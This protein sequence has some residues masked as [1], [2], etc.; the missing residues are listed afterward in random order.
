MIF[1]SSFLMSILFVSC[2]AGK[3]QEQPKAP[4]PAAVSAVTVEKQKTVYFDQYPATV[5]PLN[6]DDIRAQV[7]GYITG[8]FF[9]DGQHVKKGEKLYDIDRQQY[10]ANLDQAN[11]NLN[12]A[13]ANLSKAQQD[14]DRYADLLNQDAIARQVYDH[15]VADLESAKMQVRAS[16]SNVRNVQST[17]NYAYINAPFSGTIGISQV[18]VGSLVTANQTLLNTLSSDDPMAVDL[19]VD[20]KQIPRFTQLQKSPNSIKDSVFTLDLP[21][22]IDFNAVGHVSLI[23]RAVDP[24]TGTIRTRL[25]FPNPQNILRAGMNINVRVKNNA[26]DTAM[27]LIPYKSVTEQMG[28]Y[29]V[30]IINDSSQ[31]IQH[32][33]ALGPRINDQVVVQQGVNEGDKVITEGF[34]KIKDSSRVMITTPKSKQ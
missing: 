16:E 6:L 3:K 2:G 15:A 23:D 7:T 33:V 29:F 13:K 25:V 27:I 26:A 10:Q 8:I 34:Q 14:A 9:K 20:Q 1:I 4:P 24:Q 32:K 19:L 18:K 31:A 22:E 28:E 5:T 21:G 17:V 30:F 12:V 11:A